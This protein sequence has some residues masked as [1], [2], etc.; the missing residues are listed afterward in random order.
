MRRVVVLVAL[1]ALVAALALVAG[2]PDLARGLDL[3]TGAGVTGATESAFIV[4]LA[5]ASLAI[6]AAA[7]VLA[8]MWP[9]LKGPPSHAPT[10]RAAG[11]MAAGVAVLAWGLA[12]HLHGYH[13]CC[14]S[15]ATQQQAERLVH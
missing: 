9:S 7:V 1:G 4:L 2:W 15:G 3:A 5:W 8:V 11:L 13:V 6:V 14:S 10:W 12:S